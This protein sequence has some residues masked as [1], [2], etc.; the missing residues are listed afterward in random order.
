MSAAPVKCKNEFSD[1]LYEEDSSNLFK[2][3][4]AGPH[5]KEETDA[6]NHIKGK[7]GE[8]DAQRNDALLGLERYR[9][10]VIILMLILVVLI[11]VYFM[12]IVS[13]SSNNASVGGGRGGGRV[14]F[15]GGKK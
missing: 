8:T 12:F 1:E 10:Y 13:Q 3:L 4:F 9:L 5:S 15:S 11:I 14:R 2:K 6:L 7:I